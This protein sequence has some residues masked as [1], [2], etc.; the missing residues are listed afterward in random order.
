MPNTG[1][2][3]ELTQDLWEFSWEFYQ[4]AGVSVQLIDWQERLGA[5][6]NVVLICIWAGHRGQSLRQS[7]ISAAAEAV[8][9]WN[10]AVTAPLRQLRQ[11]LKSDWQS[12]SDDRQHVRDAVLAAELAAEKAEQAALVAALAPHPAPA[13]ADPQAVR[14]NLAL[15]LGEAAIAAP[16]SSI[17]EIWSSE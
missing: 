2:L 7:D 4:R 5:N 1:T 10:T 8:S 6:V 13:P 11:R 3:Y 9:G 16:A 12:L 17:A 15:Y 14:A